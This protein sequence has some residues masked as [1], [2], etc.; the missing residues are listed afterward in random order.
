[1]NYRIDPRLPL[2]GEVR[3][4]A[5]DRIGKAVASLEASRTMPETGL[6]DA[7][8]RFK[9]LRA[10]FRLIGRGDRAFCRKENARY[11]DIAR[12]LASSRAA[13]ALIETVDRVVKEFPDAAGAG[14]LAPI[15]ASLEARR[16]RI[17]HDRADLGPVLE[18]A[19]T[20]CGQGRVALSGLVLPDD[21]QLAADVLAAG[22]KKTMRRAARA[23]EA[24][25]KRG[26]PEDF[27]ELRKTVKAHWMHISLLRGLWPRPVKPRRKAVDALGERLGELN[28]ISVLRDLIK[29]EGK[30]LG[31]SKEIALLRRLLKRSEKP[32]RKVCLK[33]A[34]RLF[35]DRTKPTVKKVA[36]NY[37]TGAGNAPRDA[38]PADVSA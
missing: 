36:R 1:M 23:V 3:R 28:D 13:T 17:A 32:L 33:E 4:I 27:H 5:G 12:T 24:A 25:A 6:H 35:G 19:V 29:A 7:R 18:A 14:E 10:L 31:S 21:P 20:A 2:T 37:Q 26:T 15:R 34:K 9:E 38:E 16:D 8:K 22:A 11:R 30:V